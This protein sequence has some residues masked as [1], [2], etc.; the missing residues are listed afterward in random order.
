MATPKMKTPKMKTVYCLRTRIDDKAHWGNAEYYPTRKERNRVA[1]FARAIRGL[2]T[3][4]F[5]E[6]MEPT[7]AD[8]LTEEQP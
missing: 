5:E 1:S 3:H 6:K 4:S 2:R 7:I 8:R